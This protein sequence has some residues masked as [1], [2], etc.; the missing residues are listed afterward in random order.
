MKTFFEI[1]ERISRSANMIAGIS[2]LALMLL[3]VSDVVLRAFKS[4]IVGAY[5][6]VCFLGA[7]VFGLSLTFTSW[8]RKHIVVDFLTVKLPAR[9]RGGL[10][11]ATRCLSIA[12]F[13]MAGWHLILY[14]IDLQRTGEVSPTLHI[15]FYPF[16]F[17]IGCCCLIQC[18]V[19]I[20]DIGKILGGTYE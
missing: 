15:P 13:L 8:L 16:S 5:E 10:N 7:L 20:A 1:V 2:L 4:P 17:V 14:T 9:A 19:H 3:T 18:L 11:I 12:L 6:M